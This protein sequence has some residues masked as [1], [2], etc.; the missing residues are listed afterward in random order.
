VFV[1]ALLL[2]FIATDLAVTENDVPYSVTAGNNLTWTLTRNK[3]R[4]QYSDI[5]YCNGQI[6]KI[7]SSGELLGRN[8]NRIC[9]HSTDDNHPDHGDDKDP[10]CNFFEAMH[11]AQTPGA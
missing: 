2:L 7:C 4:D 1:A 9:D 6:S 10:I 5:G 11:S 3:Q 8:R